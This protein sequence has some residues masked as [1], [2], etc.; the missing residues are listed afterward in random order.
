MKGKPGDRQ[1]FKGGAGFGRGT[2]QRQL[3]VGEELRHVLSQILRPGQCRDPALANTSIT[4]TEVKIS[5]DLRN[6]TAFVVPLGGHNATE[7]VAGLR[8]SATFL[9]RRLAR[10]VKLRYAPNLT[11]ALD[12]S[13]ERADRIDALLGRPNV[14]RDLRLPT[15]RLQDSDD[16]S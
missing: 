2:R 10:E 16:A 6:A 5:P 7:V 11:F 4:V 3:R 8:R 9:R 13:F 15:T 1:Q 14:K 12:D